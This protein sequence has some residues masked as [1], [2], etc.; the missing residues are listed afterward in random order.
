[1]KKVIIANVNTI[2]RQ[3]FLINKKRIQMKKTIFIL[4][5]MLFFVQLS[6]Q[7]SDFNK[8]EG[9]TFN[10]IY[11]D[12]ISKSATINGDWGLFGGMRAGYNFN[13]KISIGLVAHGL[14]PEHIEKNYINRDGREDLYLGYGGIEASYNFSLTKDLY[15]TTAMMVG[16]GRVELEKRDDNDYFFTMEP[17]A[18]INYSFIDWFALGYSIN[19]RLASGVNYLN[20]SNASF[21]GWSM[22]LG[23][24][25][26]F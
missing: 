1:M 22:D 16:A 13:K 5:T 25:F 8:L 6:A 11:L 23:F 24:K 21:S 19:Y 14:I 10:K 12:V 18:S 9:G 26:S 3:H 4:S 17:G 20:Y 15:L 7:T 2:L